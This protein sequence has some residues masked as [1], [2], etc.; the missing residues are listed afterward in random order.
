MKRSISII[1]QAVEKAAEH[2]ATLEDQLKSIDTVNRDKCGDAL[3]GLRNAADL[4]R[5]EAV[6]LLIDI[7]LGRFP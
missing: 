6:E 3:N 5:S 4:M 7:E 1:K 2:L